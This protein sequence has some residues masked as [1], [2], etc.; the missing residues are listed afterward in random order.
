MEPSG[1]S[2]SRYMGPRI[3]SISS[4]VYPKAFWTPTFRSGTVAPD[5]PD[6]LAGGTSVTRRVRSH[7]G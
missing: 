6:K 5:L 3:N 2:P 1:S 4:R 7:S